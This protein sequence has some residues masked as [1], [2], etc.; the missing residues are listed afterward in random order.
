MIFDH[1]YD[2]K[3]KNA[4]EKGKHISKPIVIGKN[5]WIGA[6]SIIL[7]GSQ[8]G[9]NCIVGAGSVIKGKYEDNQIIIQRRNTIVSAI[10]RNRKYEESITNSR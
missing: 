3:D 8:I 9:D 4:F 10:G 7:K 5:C 1:D 6:G 2:Y